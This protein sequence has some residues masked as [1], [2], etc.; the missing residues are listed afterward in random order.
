MFHIDTELLFCPIED[1]DAKNQ[2]FFASLT[3]PPQ[4]DIAKKGKKIVK[5]YR[6]SKREFLLKGLPKEL[7]AIMQASIISEQRRGKNGPSNKITG[8]EHDDAYI[9]SKKRETA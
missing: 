8:T 5:G 7:R 4:E 9:Q 3:P 2:E 6:Q 1:Q